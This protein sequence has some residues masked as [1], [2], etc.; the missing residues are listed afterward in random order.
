MKNLVILFFIILYVLAPATAQADAGLPMLVLLWPLS[1]IAFIPVVI[2]EA[3]IAKRIL[4]L[5]WKQA[6]IRTGGIRHERPL[7]TPRVCLKRDYEGF[8]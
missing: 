1:W 3:W 4:G 8:C 7:S 5:M 2:I 6:F